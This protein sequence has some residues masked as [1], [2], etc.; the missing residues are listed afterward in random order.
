MV[1][2]EHL[3]RAP[4]TSVLS[5]V[6]VVPRQLEHGVEPGADPAGLRA[7]VAGALQLA[8]L[9]QR[10]LADLVG[11]VGRLD[12]GAVVVG[13]VRLVLAELLAD[14]GELLAQQELALALLHALAHVVADL[15]GDLELGQ[16]LAGPVDR[17]SSA[18][19]STSGVSSSSRFCSSVRY[20]A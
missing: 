17:P 14:G 19:R 16:V 4:A 3:A 1:G 12:A 20:G 18:A 11:Q 10:G 8:D 6:R 15:L 7:L 9:A 2:V 5:S 13:A